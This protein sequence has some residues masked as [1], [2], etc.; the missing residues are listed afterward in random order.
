[1]D[2]NAISN[3]K[4]G[5]MR[6]F[7]T[8]KKIFNSLSVVLTFGL[9]TAVV[10]AGCGGSGGESA[11][12]NGGSFVVAV[13][14]GQPV[15]YTEGATIGG[16]PDP[17][18]MST[19]MSGFGATDMTMIIMAAEYNAS[20]STRYNVVLEIL[21]EG[22]TV[23]DYPVDSNSMNMVF[24]A[25]NPNIYWPSFAGHAGTIRITRYDS[26]KIEGE[27]VGL[28]LEEEATQNVIIFDCNF[29][30][31]PGFDMGGYIP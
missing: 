15:A 22:S 29:S 24:F 1:M 2:E 3:V 17:A 13:D 27:I 11:F 6:Y 5:E 26:S 21:L 10:V 20:A 16:M 31:T 19:V 14:G 4:E 8:K 25:D 18:M 7:M 9:M 12:G 30:I 28:S 23:G